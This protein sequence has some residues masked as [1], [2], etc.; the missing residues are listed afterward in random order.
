ML[1][2]AFVLVTNKQVS[3]IHYETHCNW[4]LHITTVCNKIRKR[5]IEKKREKFPFKSYN[6]P[7]DLLL[8]LNLKQKIHKLIYSIVSEI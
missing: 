5:L 6:R 8:L 3:Q 1:L 7:N 2:G 4:K